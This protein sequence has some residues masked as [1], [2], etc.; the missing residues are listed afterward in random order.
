MKNKTATGY[1]LLRTRILLCLTFFFLKFLSFLFPQNSIP[2]E[3]TGL[4]EFSPPE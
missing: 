4:L 2:M 1:E 3:S